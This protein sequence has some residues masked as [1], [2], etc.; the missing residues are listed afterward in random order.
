MKLK[1]FLFCSLFSFQNLAQKTKL[2]YPKDYFL[3][4]INPKQQNYLAGGM[5]DLRADH[6]HAGIDI[7]TQG[8]EGLAV[9]ATADGYVSE[10]RVQTSGYG[11]VIFL[12]HPNGYVSVYGHLKEF[13]EPLATYVKKKR[14]ESQTFEIQLK[15]TPSEFVVKKGQIIGYSGN[16][17]GSAGPHLHFEIRDANNNILNPLNF[18][19]SEIKDNTPPIFQQLYIKTLS[20]DARVNGEFGRKAFTPIKKP[21][22]TYTLNANVSVVGEIGLELM[23][24][25][26]MNDTHNSNGLTCTELLVDGQE[27]H[28]FHLEQ[29]PN[30]LSH[31]INV[32]TD[33]AYEKTIGHRI[34]KL[35]QDDGNEELPVYKAILSKGKLNLEDG[36]THQVSIKIWDAYENGSTLNFTIKGEKPES[37]VTASPNKLPININYSTDDNTLIIKARNLKTVNSIAILN[38]EKSS[39]EL[40]ISYVKNNEAVYLWDL[41][42]GLPK[43]IRID[44]VEKALNLQKTI[45]PNQASSYVSDK[46]SIIFDTKTLYDT[47]YLE[48]NSIA[49]RIEIGQPTIPLRNSINVSFQPDINVSLPEKTSVYYTSRNQRRFLGGKWNSDRIVFKAGLLGQFTLLTDTIP[50]KASFVSKSPNYVAIRIYDNLSGIKSFKTYLNDTYILAD[51]DAKRALLWT[52]K[53]DSTQ[54]FIGKLRLDLEDNQGNKSSFVTEVDEHTKVVATKKEKHVKTK[55]K[56]E[57]KAKKSAKK[58]KKH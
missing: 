46:L 14:L 43:S 36:K 1:I 26:K 57:A 9:L 19:F 16:T 42:K 38:F 52:V 27:I 23:A 49:N 8:R 7:K 48:T 37:S 22:G 47:L 35:F 10:I 45:L 28:Y 15:P 58:K 12:T 53:S 56:H 33:Y 5:G 3:F 34:Q 11:N 44:S 31:D 20:T 4:P 29:F 40:A 21:D 30:A 24:V 32:H 6:F 2:L 50:P 13:V 18:G 39:T 17:G 25:D 55:H 51:Y 54:N 41:K